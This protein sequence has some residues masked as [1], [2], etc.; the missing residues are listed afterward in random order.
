MTCHE[1][2]PSTSECR[3]ENLL[4]VMASVQNVK[5]TFSTIIPVYW[6]SIYCY[7]LITF[8]QPTVSKKY[9]G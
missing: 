9:R 7:N 4:T 5:P 3:L 2:E 8:L 6:L 1:I